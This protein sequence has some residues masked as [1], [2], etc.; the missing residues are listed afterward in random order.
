MDDLRRRH[1]IALDLHAVPF[2]LARVGLA[3]PVPLQPAV[4]VVLLAELDPAAVIPAEVEHVGFHHLQPQ[5]HQPL[6]SHALIHPAADQAAAAHGGGAGDQRL[7]A[8]PVQLPGVVAL[9][10][11]GPVVPGLLIPAAAALR[12]A[13]DAVAHPV[14]SDHPNGPVGPRVAVHQILM[15]PRQQPPGGADVR[16][17][18]A[19][20]GVPVLCAAALLC[21]LERP[22]VGDGQLFLR[23]LQG[24]F[25]LIAGGSLGHQSLLKLA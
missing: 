11:V 13:D 9:H 3:D 7:Q 6:I 12:A 1:E 8:V 18:P 23:G 17:G 2:R 4:A 5:A 14:V 19:V 15:P 20:A 25:Q 24:Q 10:R 22:Q 16:V 21:R